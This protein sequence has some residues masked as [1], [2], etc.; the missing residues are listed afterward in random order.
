MAYFTDDE[1]IEI[2]SILEGGW[3]NARDD[4]D[5]LAKKRFDRMMHEV[6]TDKPQLDASDVAYIVEQLEDVFEPDDEAAIKSAID[7]LKTLNG[8]SKA[9]ALAFVI[10]V[11]ARY[12]ENSEECYSERIEAHHT[13]DDLRRIV[14]KDYAGTAQDLEDA[15]YLRDLWRAINILQEKPADEKLTYEREWG[16]R[17]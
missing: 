3:T 2:H 4:G 12:G 5:V 17:V 9:E 7:K 15:K 8:I 16:N 14:N 11:A 10:S 13:D 1:L 6:T